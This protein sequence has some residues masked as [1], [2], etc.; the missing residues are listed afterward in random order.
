MLDDKIVT[1][2]RNTHFNSISILNYGYPFTT[3][4]D[5]VQ[6]DLLHFWPVLKT[7][8]KEQISYLRPLCYF[9]EELSCQSV[10]VTIAY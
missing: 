1:L 10:V 3:L 9:L 5:S 7:L 8:K 4:E 6:K 2:F